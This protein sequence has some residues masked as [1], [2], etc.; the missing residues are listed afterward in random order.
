MS[1]QVDELKGMLSE[2]KGYFQKFPVPPQEPERMLVMNNGGFMRMDA[3]DP[4]HETLQQLCRDAT[5]KWKVMSAVNM[6]GG[7]KQYTA[8]GCIPVADENGETHAIARAKGDACGPTGLHILE[9]GGNECPRKITMCQ[10]VTARGKPLTVNGIADMAKE[11]FAVP[12]DMTAAAKVDPEMA[13]FLELMANGE[14]PFPADPNSRPEINSYAAECLT[15]PTMFYSGVPIF[16]EGKVMGS[17]CLGEDFVLY[18]CPVCHTLLTSAQHDPRSVAPERPSSYDPEEGPKELQEWST[19]MTTAL[20]THLQQTRVASAQSAMMQQV[21]VE[22]SRD[23]TA[24]IS[25]K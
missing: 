16:V 3:K 2:V 14:G 22:E 11:G 10:H 4:A 25:L 5:Q 23:H 1:R 15:S 20:E 19:R 18:K 12:T 13:K 7:L 21:V 24:M 6:I 17:F 9:L 8:A